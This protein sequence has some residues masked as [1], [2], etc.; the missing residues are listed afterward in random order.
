MEEGPRKSTAEV[1]AAMSRLK[2]YQEGDIDAIMKDVLEK[3]AEDDTEYR[4]VTWVETTNRYFEHYLSVE[5]HVYEDGVKI[6][7][8]AVEKIDRSDPDSV[9]GSA[10][11][12]DGTVVKP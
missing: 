10:F 5:E 1:Q 6:Q 11:S 2:A 8:F 12:K 7:K 9:L 3:E 4:V